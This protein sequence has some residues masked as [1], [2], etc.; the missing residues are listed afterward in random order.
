MKP[1]VTSLLV[2]WT[3]GLMAGKQD[4]ERERHKW[5]GGY[6]HLVLYPLS[7]PYMGPFLMLYGSAIL[8][9][10]LNPALACLMAVNPQVVRQSDPEVTY[11][12]HIHL[13]GIAQKVHP[14]R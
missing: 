7:A 14:L 8:R 1:V 10:I 11:L 5:R 3:K 4:T 9:D 2:P 13:L 6:L 12:I